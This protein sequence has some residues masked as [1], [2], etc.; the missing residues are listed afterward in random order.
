MKHRNSLETYNRWLFKINTN[1]YITKYHNW[2]TGVVIMSIALVILLGTMS[3]QRQTHRTRRPTILT[4][5]QLK[6]PQQMEQLKLPQQ[7]EATKPL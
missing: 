4:S 3:L 6:L 2:L 7:M 5:E 1:N